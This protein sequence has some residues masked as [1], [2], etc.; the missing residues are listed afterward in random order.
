LGATNRH[1]ETGDSASASFSD[2]V[3]ALAV[4]TT[5]VILGTAFAFCFLANIAL[6]SCGLYGTSGNIIA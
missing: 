1:A 2:S 5:T 3:L 4:A 6:A